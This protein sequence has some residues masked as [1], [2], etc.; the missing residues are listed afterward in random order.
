MAEH[1]GGLNRRESYWTLTWPLV[2][3]C[4]T[5]DE[6]RFGLRFGLGKL[7]GPWVARRLEVVEVRRAPGTQRG[8]EISMD[9]SRQWVFLPLGD[10]HALLGELRGLGYPVVHD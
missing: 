2:A 4:A 6:L 7:G 10:L 8:I 3:L 5:A 1:I 9:V